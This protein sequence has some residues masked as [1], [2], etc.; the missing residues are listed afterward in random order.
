VRRRAARGANH[1]ARTV[2]GFGRE[3]TSFDQRRLDPR[4]HRE[5]FE[6]YFRV[7]P[8]ETLPGGAVGFDLGCG[9]GRWAKLVAPRVGRL[10][11][12]DASVEAVRVARGSLVDAPNCTFTA[13]SVDAL[14][15]PDASMDFGYS[16]G[17]L[18][19]VPDTPAGIRA[20]V[21]K[22]RPG[23]PFLLCLYYAFDNRPRWFRWLWR[24]TEIGRAL[25][26]RLPFPLRR[27]VTEVIAVTVYWPLA[28][29]A[30]L[31]ER[32]G[33]DVDAWPLSFYRRR[34]LYT[35]RTDALDRFGTL[36]EQRFTA[37]Q[38]RQM[39]EAA[40]LEEIR[41]SDSPPYWC[42]VGRRK[43]GGRSEVARGPDSC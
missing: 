43:G 17:V 7:F 34:S 18:H 22:L 21:A 24:T 8:W 15:L 13:A 4:E 12:L 14:P 41:F 5:L 26:S 6:A 28:R 36:L 16:L 2:D 9:S 23:A 19:H 32:L 37:A 30:S 27:G 11:C 40:G 3:W 38:I 1:D 25:V 39:M 29:A 42:A 35:M 31:G 33:V 20:C 10:H